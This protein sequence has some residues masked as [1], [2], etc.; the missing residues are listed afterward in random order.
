VETELGDPVAGAVVRFRWDWPMSFTGKAFLARGVESPA[1]FLS[2]T[3]RFTGGSGTFEVG[4]PPG[5]VRVEVTAKGFLDPEPLDLVVAPGAQVGDLVVTLPSGGIV[6]G[7]VQP[8]TGVGGTR[9]VSVTGETSNA[10]RV[11]DD[12]GRFRVT[13]LSTGLSTGRYTVRA[14][15]TREEVEAIL[16]DL[17][18][19]AKGLLT[20]RVEVDVAEGEITDVVL[21]AR[22]F[23]LARVIGTVTLDGGPI[24]AGFVTGTTVDGPEGMQLS[25]RTKITLADPGR[26]EAVVTPGT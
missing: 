10:D 22:E 17:C 15:A 16:G 12:D 20:R 18:E 9:H 3:S 4:V 25:V 13:G 1:Y 2:G 21:A 8:L 5:P 26:F 23:D 11:V 6:R 24:V 19:G 7:L 14:D